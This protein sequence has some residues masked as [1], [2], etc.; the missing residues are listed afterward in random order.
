MDD[1]LRYKFEE[2][3]KVIYD[4]L[5]DQDVCMYFNDDMR[6]WL[7]DTLNNNPLTKSD[8]RKYKIKS[9]LKDA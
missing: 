6:D 1:D 2:D 4:S 3:K 7:L 8:E 5:T 9:L